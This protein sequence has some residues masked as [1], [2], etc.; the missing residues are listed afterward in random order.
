M[1]RIFIMCVAVLLLAVIFTG[2]QTAQSAP[3][4][5]DVVP[6]EVPNEASDKF[7]RI[8]Y[9]DFDSEIQTKIKSK[10]NEAGNMLIKNNLGDYYFIIFAG[11]KPTGGYDIEITD[12]NI[13]DDITNIIVKETSPSKDMMVTQALT[14]PMHIIKINEVT[15][16]ITV[17]KDGKITSDSVQIINEYITV[18]EI[19]EFG[20]D[21][22]HILTG[23]I[24]EIFKVDKNEIMNFYLGE[25]VGVIKND[26]DTYTLESYKNSDFTTRYTNM[27]DIISTIS[28]DL[29]EINDKKFTLNTLDGDMEFEA[30][31]KLAL[32]K[33]T[34]VTIEYLKREDGN[35]LTDI[36]NEDSKINLTIKNISR[37]EN[38]GIMIID[39]VDDNELEYVVYVL[40]RTVLNFNLSDLKENDSLTVYPEVIRECYP[41]EIDAKMIKKQ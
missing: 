32:E 6:N 30:Y 4:N 39:T 20:K 24:A 41:A 19:I 18:G 29:K 37:S 34:E 25:T 26:D 8:S 11:E 2:C 9:K 40:G 36:Y 15:D 35:I 7:E 23:D 17:I 1:K 12:V 28:G 3:T 31:D 10:R 22:V 14:Y 13:T 21:S 27:G 33:G 38:T 16:N 5:D